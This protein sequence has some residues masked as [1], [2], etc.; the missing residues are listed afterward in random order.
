ME[1]KQ[2]IN[3]T[4]ND[5]E[6]FFAHEMSVNFNPMQFILDFRSV[7]PRNDP[8]TKGRP[9]LHLKHNVIMV[10][11]WHMIQIRDVFNRMIEAYEKEFGKIKKPKAIETFEKKQSKG[12]KE[13]KKQ[14]DEAE[15]EAPSYFG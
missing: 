8:R 9:S 11:P 7:T 12:A 13:N 15:T 3:L 4:I 1:Q 10:D 2:S 5:G 14:K 6:P